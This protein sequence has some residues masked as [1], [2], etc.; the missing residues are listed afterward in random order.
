MIN[1]VTFY[2]IEMVVLIYTGANITIRLPLRF[3]LD[4]F[5]ST[6][7]SCCL[8]LGLDLRFGS[9][10]GVNFGLDFGQVQIGS[11]SN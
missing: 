10:L 6:K 1:K 7:L 4:G 3:S 2:S 8:N 9:G 11:G 5:G